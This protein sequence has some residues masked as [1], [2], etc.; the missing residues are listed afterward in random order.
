MCLSIEVDS[1]ER[2][3]EKGTAEGYEWVV[4]HN[5]MG[6]RC[7]YV[8][9]VEGHPWY[10]GGY[11]IDADVHGGVT[12]TEHDVPCGKGEDSGYWVGFDCAHYLDAPDPELTEAPIPSVLQHGQIRTQEYVRNECISLCNSAA[13]A[14]KQSQSTFVARDY[15]DARLYQLARLVKGQR[16]QSVES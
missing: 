4:S 2:I 8:K 12:F 5:T 3:L 14:Y 16:P 15:Q 11:D 9:V 10:G 1:P 6:Y 13:L 7:G